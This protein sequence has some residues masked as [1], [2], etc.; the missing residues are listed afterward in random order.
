MRKRRSSLLMTDAPMTEREPRAASPTAASRYRSLL[1]AFCVRLCVAITLAVVVLLAVELYAY[2][3]YRHAAANVQEPAV[4]L[5]LGSATAEEHEYWEEF[6]QSNKVIYHQYVLWRRAP[7][8]GSMISIDAEGVRQTLHTRCDGQTF[9]IWMFGDS[10]MWGAG[11]KDGETIP[12]FIASDYEKAGKPVCIVNYAEKGWSNTQETLELIQLLKHA[13]RKPDIVLFY[14]GGTEA[15]AA[16]Q[17][18]EADVHSNYGM[19]REFLDNW[20]KRRKAGFFYL[21]NT[22]TYRLLQEISQRLPFRPKPENSPLQEMEV[23]GLSEAVVQNYAANMSI[24]DLL[25]KQYG[26]RPIFIWYPNLAVGHKTLTEYEQEVLRQQYREFPN[27]GRM[28]QAVYNRSGEI[29]HADFYN[30]SDSVDDRKDSLY[31]GLSHMRS[32][33]T[34]IMADRL[35]AILEGKK[36]IAPQRLGAAASARANQHTMQLNS[37]QPSEP[38]VR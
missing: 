11:T 33:G 5:D 25:A 30:L 23:V 6:E 10:V 36:S 12:S 18:R 24:V 22:N 9:T 27:L 20:G 4:R 31:I 26:F 19:F 28:Y 29:Q 16:Y 14:D 1:G 15:F 32:E 37:N 13:A 17:A 21:Q 2:R 35:F 3:R 38:S 8:Q 34:E 7:Y